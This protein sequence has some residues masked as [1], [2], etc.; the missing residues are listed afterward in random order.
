MIEQYLQRSGVDTVLGNVTISLSPCIILF[1]ICGNDTPYGFS[2]VMTMFYT[3]IYKYVLHTYV[4][5]SMHL[6]RLIMINSFQ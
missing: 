6:D 4:A 5:I 3:R 2:T 1:Q